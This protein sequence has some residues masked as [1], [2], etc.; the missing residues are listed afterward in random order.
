M[1]SEKSLTKFSSVYKNIIK[2]VDKKV[3]EELKRIINS[4]EKELVFGRSE[5]GL[6]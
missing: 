4:A 1:S 2:N 6:A 3:E 5:N